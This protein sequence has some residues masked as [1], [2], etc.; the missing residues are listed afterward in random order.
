MTITETQAGTGGEKN[1]LL[2]PLFKASIPNLD[3]F[4]PGPRGH[5]MTFT[6]DNISLSRHASRLQHTRAPL[7]TCHKMD[8]RRRW[9]E[10][11]RGQRRQMRQRRCCQRRRRRRQR[12]RPWPQ[13]HRQLAVHRVGNCAAAAAAA[14]CAGPD[15]IGRR[16]FD[17]RRGS[18]A[19]HQH[20]DLS[21]FFFSKKKIL[22]RVGSRRCVAIHGDEYLREEQGECS[23]ANNN[24]NSSSKLVWLQLHSNR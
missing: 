11:G 14:A 15:F 5:R 10:N 23:K 6:I 17:F 16:V 22:Q 12:T 13:R 20:G 4:H 1:K 24:N 2:R 21:T 19:P 3:E 7:S 18:H 9:G 8:G